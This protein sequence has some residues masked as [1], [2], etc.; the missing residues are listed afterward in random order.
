MKW[1]MYF[2]TVL[3]IEKKLK[4]WLTSRSNYNFTKHQ[5]KIMSSEHFHIYKINKNFANSFLVF[6]VLFFLFSIGI[7][8]YSLIVDQSVAWHYLLFSFQG[9]IALFQALVA[10]KNRRYFVEWDE[11]QISY[12]LP[13]TP[14]IESIRFSDIESAK[15]NK[16]SIELMLKNGTTKNVNLKS[17]FLPQKTKL[18]EKFETFQ[19]EAIYRVN[20]EELHE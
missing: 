19:K 17:L 15:I 20:Q 13:K 3:I 7:F 2:A 1:S 8:I 11:Q 5:L 18:K 10:I 9:L 16:M 14:G 12:W 4:I 6:G